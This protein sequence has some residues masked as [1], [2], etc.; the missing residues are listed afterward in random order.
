MKKILVPIDA[1]GLNEKTFNY[2]RDLSK[3]YGAD[4]LLLNVVSSNNMASRITP[5]ITM[6]NNYFDNIDMQDTFKISNQ[7]LE[8][9]K[10]KFT[11]VG[12]ECSIKSDIGNIALVIIDV[13]E[14]EKVDMIIMPDKSDSAIKH[15]LLGNIT[16]K[17]VHHASVPVLVV[18]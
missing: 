13:S 4:I 7:I 2:A 15:F 11:S 17:V 6:Y 12:I 18:K 14:E 10:L 3:L 9:E 1:L 16:D 8:N 5:N